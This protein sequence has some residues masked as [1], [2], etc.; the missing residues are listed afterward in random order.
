MSLL[1]VWLAV[2]AV[3]ILLGLG[4][5]LGKPSDGGLG[6]IPKRVELA[7]SVIMVVVG[8]AVWLVYAR[9]TLLE[10]ASFA[11]ALGM[12]AGFLGDLIMGKVVPTPNR[13]IFSILAFGVGHVLYIVGFSQTAQVVGLTAPL[14]LWPLWVGGLILAAV[15]WRGMVY[16]PRAPSALNVGSLLYVALIAVMAAAGT[17]LAVQDAR[18]VL[19]ALGGALF[20]LSD[21]ILGNREFRG[22]HWPFVN[23]I[24]W[25][26]YIFG[27][28]LIV[29]TTVYALPLA[30]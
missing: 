30:L 12:A 11:L 29:L 28:A 9:G 10:G 22:S 2:A 25:V 24:V 6:R 3:P 14:A 1:P 17:G 7:T 19:T 8:L 5:A 18:F 16:S 23:D 26:T 27:Q 15:L 13:L 20:L 4:F 21:L